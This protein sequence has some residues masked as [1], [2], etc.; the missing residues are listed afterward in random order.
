[1]GSKIQKSAGSPRACEKPSVCILKA[2]SSATA[3]WHS[4]DSVT[5]K[6]TACSRCPPRPEL[7]HHV[8]R[9]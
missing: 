9:S 8:L 4:L 3:H 6:T 7:T 1:M 2:F 5:K